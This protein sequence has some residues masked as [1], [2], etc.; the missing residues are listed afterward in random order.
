MTIM[1]PFSCVWK[2][3]QYIDDTWDDIDNYYTIIK[4][5][6]VVKRH[7]S[8][9]VVVV[10]VFWLYPFR[11]SVFFCAK[12]VFFAPK[13]IEIFLSLHQN[14]SVIHQKGRDINGTKISFCVNG[15]K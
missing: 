13:K 4:H 15:E 3:A 10:G 6:K 1:I 14:C 12:K 8:A 9:G 2:F 5:E 11:P 7:V